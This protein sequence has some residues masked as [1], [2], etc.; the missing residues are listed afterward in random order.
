MNKEILGCDQASTIYFQVPLRKKP[1]FKTVF[2]L[3]YIPSQIFILKDKCDYQKL[4]ETLTEY[5]S[6]FSSTRNDESRNSDCMT[7]SHKDATVSKRSKKTRSK[8]KNQDEIF[9]RNTFN[10]QDSLEE[11]Q[12]NETLI[13]ISRRPPKSLKSIN[14]RKSITSFNNG[15]KSH[16]EL[17]LDKNINERASS[18]SL[19]TNRDL[20]K[21]E[22][23]HNS[24][25]KHALRHLRCQR[26]R[27]K[28]RN[29]IINA[30]SSM[31]NLTNFD[32]SC[33]KS[34]EK[35]PAE[36]EIKSPATSNTCSYGSDNEKKN[37]A[38]NPVDK[39][40]VQ[41]MI[42]DRMKSIL[43]KAKSRN[44][45]KENS[46]IEVNVN[47]IPEKPL[48]RNLSA[49]TP[50]KSA[51]KKTSK[52]V[53]EYDPNGLMKTVAKRKSV[54]FSEDS[55]SVQIP[56]VN[57]DLH[58]PINKP[59]IEKAKSEY[60]LK[61]DPSINE[62]FLTTDDDISVPRSPYVP[63][64]GF[65]EDLIPKFNAYENKKERHVRNFSYDHTIELKKFEK[66]METEPK[67]FDHRITV[68]K[69]NSD[70]GKSQDLSDDKEQND[71]KCKQ[72][73]LKSWDSNSI[74]FS[75]LLDAYEVNSQ[76]SNFKKGPLYDIAILPIY[77]FKRHNKFLNLA[78]EYCSSEYYHEINRA[79][80]ITEGKFFYDSGELYYKG[81]ILNNKYKHGT[82]KIFHKN[83]TI[84]FSGEFKFDNIEGFDCKIHDDKG[85]LEFQGRILKGKIEGMG[86]SYWKTGQLRYKGIFR[87]SQPHG[88]KCQIFY[89][90]GTCNYD[91]AL[92]EGKRQGY[93]RVYHRN[94]QLNYEGLFVN[95]SAG[96]EN[97]CVYD[98]KAR[99]IYVGT[100]IDGNFIFK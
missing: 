78:K 70:D 71:L 90:N 23:I 58:L 4:H 29:S 14:H 62:R 97:Q 80:L 26:N 16:R 64:K 3:E 34:P 2:H 19:A 98:N 25:K 87:N 44:V 47:Q 6:T 74:N 65:G 33:Y 31:N 39:T 10:D 95:N 73:S 60:K 30:D 96:G 61:I 92:K 28:S 81:E 13:K 85:N 50:P 9:S 38:E 86:R 79:M 75:S 53:I 100:I 12:K 67:D 11:N 77:P 72:R 24:K 91:G 84:M 32:E 27:S 56:R 66:R 46:V 20:S 41:L 15:Y 18:K 17:N 36:L 8:V 94:A 51:L 48:S 1:E 82:G 55:I 89:S 88:G 54:Y 68:I 57:Y 7:I 63:G 45:T 83:G 49:V 21:N 22:K 42:I 35:K 59:T 69:V 37:L 5:I 99:L 40:T 76:I 52:K 93:G 43:D